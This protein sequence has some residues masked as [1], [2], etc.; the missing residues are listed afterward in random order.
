ME[1][2]FTVLTRWLCKCTFVRIS[3]QLTAS[4]IRT[5]L[6]CHLDGLSKNK[7]NIRVLLRHN[8]QTFLLLNVLNALKPSP[9][10]DHPNRDKKMSVPWIDRECSGSP[11]KTAALCRRWAVNVP[12]DPNHRW[13]CC[14]VP[15]CSGRTGSQSGIRGCCWTCWSSWCWIC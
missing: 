4:W 6:P 11:C 12:R 2:N 3:T 10:I 7:L 14:C 1:L 13:S 15:L 5:P 9:R 8:T